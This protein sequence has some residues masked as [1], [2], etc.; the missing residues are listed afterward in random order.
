MAAQYQLVMQSGPTPGKTF[1]LEGD[2]I[3]IGREATNGIAI[4]DA[5]I[6]RR[7]S[8][9]VFQGGK[10]VLSD[11]GS[12][13]GTF[14]NGRRIVGQHILVPGEV[15]ALGEQISLV[16][17]VVAQADPNATMISSAAHTPAAAPRAS[18]PVP[19]PAARPVP[20]SY[21][22]QV[23]ADPEIAAPAAKR[24]PNR[25]V[26]IV[27]VV[28][29]LLICCCVVVPF[30]YDQMNLWCSPVTSWLVPMIGGACP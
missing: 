21:A 19:P 26:I 28:V 29:L 30:V 6:S 15:V 18:A 10:Y 27:A 3:M 17:E 11:L 4:N 5:E 16:F 7:H 22:G 24:G 8:Q 13:N 23:P 1:P 12:T 14:V 25:T 2:V 20:Q 9:L